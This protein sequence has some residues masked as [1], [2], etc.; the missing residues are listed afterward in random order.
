MYKPTKLTGNEDFERMLGSLVEADLEIVKV[1]EVEDRNHNQ[2]WNI[3][4]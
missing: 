2:T 4:P 3:D 1:P